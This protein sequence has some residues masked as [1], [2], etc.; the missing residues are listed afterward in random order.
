MKIDFK[1]LVYYD[2]ASPSCLR[3]LNDLY[4]GMYYS[5]LHVKAGDVFGSLHHSGYWRTSTAKTKGIKSYACHRIVWE[6]FNGEIPTGYQ[7][8]HIN[9]D[10]G[11]N[12][13]SNLR[14]VERKINARNQK[15]PSNNS[16]SVMGVSKFVKKRGLKCYVSW[17]AQWTRLD[18]K[19]GSKSFLVSK[20]GNEEAFRLACEHRN[21]AMAELNEQGAGY[22]DRHLGRH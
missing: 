19:R 15:I 11:D 16:S 9:G 13:I 8:D 21:K 4:R 10:R 2:E 1:K 5:V 6:L 14:L 17:V 12:R 20:Y 3:V 18:G 22:T 7:I